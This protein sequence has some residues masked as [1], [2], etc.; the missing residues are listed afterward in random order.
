MRSLSD[1]EIAIIL[2]LVGEEFPE[3]QKLR[4]QLACSRINE[5]ADGNILEFETIFPDKFSGVRTILGEGSID[6][7]D[8]IPI[9]LTLLQ[10]DGYLWHLDISRV[11][12]G[13]IKT[14][15]KPQNLRALGYGKGLTLG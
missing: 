11:D 3:L 5:I 14:N 2:K 9:I 12:S 1:D 10:K 13:R 15:L 6:D 4:A 8:G 7:L